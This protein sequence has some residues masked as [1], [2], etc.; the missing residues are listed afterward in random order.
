M[1]NWALIAMTV[2]VV[3]MLTACGGE[4]PTGTGGGS[5]GSGGGFGAG[6]GAGGGAGSTCGAQNCTGCCFNGAC[7][8]GSAATGCG[9]AGATCSACNSNQ[10]C[11]VD[12]TCG[13]DPEST[14]VV[15]PTSAQITSNNNG[16]AWD[17]DG[18]APDPQ[19]FMTCGD[20]TAATS[21]P[22]ASDTYRPTWTTGGCSAK[23]K[24]LLRA[25]W[26]FRVY[27]IDAVVDDT[28]TSSLV[29]TITEAN[30]SAGSFTLLPSGGLQS[31]SVA[32]RRQ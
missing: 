22:E 21:T 20:M 12:Q 19:V 4:P 8:T 17:G 16:S 10:V 18:S 5:G 15:Q 3:S 29:V 30:F 23:A 27:D 26:S 31:M 14:W 9:K 28:I 1:K 13:V 11:R 2:A 25:G 6:G 7:Q 24:D 32:L